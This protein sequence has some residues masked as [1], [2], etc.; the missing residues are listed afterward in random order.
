MNDHSLEI[1]HWC[2][3]G[4]DEDDNNEEELGQCFHW[5]YMIKFRGLEQKQDPPEHWQI[6]TQAGNIQRMEML[7]A[8]HD[9]YFGFSRPQRRL[10]L[11]SSLRAAGALTPRFLAQRTCDRHQLLATLPLNTSRRRL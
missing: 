10:Q 5:A 11:S 8:N 9:G 1:K 6:K 2:S 7:E 3:N 4:G